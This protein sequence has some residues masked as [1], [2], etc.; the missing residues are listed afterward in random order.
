MARH[1]V[2]FITVD[3]QEAA[4][5]GHDVH[6]FGSQFDVAES[7]IDIL[8]QRFIM[9]AGNQHL[10]AQKSLVDQIGEETDHDDE[11]TCRGDSVQS[12]K[13]LFQDDKKLSL[14]A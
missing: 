5:V 3:Q 12:L 2:E 13:A 11:R 4:T 6:V 14:L 9:V 7:S 8:A 1:L 10:L